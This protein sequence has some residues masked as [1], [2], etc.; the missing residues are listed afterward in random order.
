MNYQKINIDVSYLNDNF[1]D[2]CITL[3]ITSIKYLR[4]GGD[5]P[6]RRWWSAS[7]HESPCLDATIFRSTHPRTVTCNIYG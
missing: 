1:F 7:R 4:D 3:Y 2:R 6:W 5:L